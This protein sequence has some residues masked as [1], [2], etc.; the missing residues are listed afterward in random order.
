MQRRTFLAAALAWPAGRALAK[1]PALFSTGGLAIHGYDP[2]AYFTDSRPVQGDPKIALKWGGAMWLFASVGNRSAFETDARAYAPQY[3]GY[4]A[5]AMAQGAVATT[6]PEA[7][8]VHE[9]R[10][11]LNFSTGVRRI[12]RQ[13]IS[14]NIRK[15]DGFWPEALNG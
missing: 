12:W 4:C 15:A 2:V 13:D 8:T 1:A 9:G 10:L 5:Y 7:W 3:G 6:V 11:F 14:G